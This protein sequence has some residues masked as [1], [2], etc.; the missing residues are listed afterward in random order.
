MLIK[1]SL[2]VKHYT[3]FFYILEVNIWSKFQR[4]S[5]WQ[6]NILNKILLVILLWDIYLIPYMAENCTID[7]FDSLFYSRKNVTQYIYKVC[8]YIN[9]YYKK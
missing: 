7:P 5:T 2:I 6:V 9:T 8:V 1:L 3:S 4:N